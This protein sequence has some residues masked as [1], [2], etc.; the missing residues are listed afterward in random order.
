[1]PLQLLVTGTEDLGPKAAGLVPIAKD[2]SFRT[3]LMDKYKGGSAQFG[4]LW[5]GAYSVADQGGIFGQ[6]SVLKFEA[7]R[8]EN[9]GLSAASTRAGPDG[10][11]KLNRMLATALEQ[12]CGLNDEPA[13]SPACCASGSR[14]CPSSR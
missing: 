13:R 4:D 6:V 12:R 9:F 10:I 8:A 3:S 11:S 5:S 2:L 14:V 1:M 7:G